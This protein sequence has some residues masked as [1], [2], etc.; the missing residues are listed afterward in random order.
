MS[1]PP[2]SNTSR[3]SS[4]S[5]SFV[6][7]ASKSSSC[8]SRLAVTSSRT[9]FVR[10]LRRDTLLV[11]M[12][13]ANNETGVLQPVMEVAGL[14]AG[15]GVLF[16]VDAAQTFGKE[17]EGLRRVSIV[18]SC[19]SAVTR[20]TGR[21]GSVRSTFAGRGVETDSVEA[22]HVGRR[23]RDGAE[24]RHSAGATDRRARDSSRTGREGVP[25]AKAVKPRG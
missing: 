19:R 5:T 25:A 13:H 4:R 8:R 3:S 17:V 7:S 24:A 23:S 18:I 12:M 20:S 11:S 1:S 10:R 6:R 16:H 14:L 15:S 21:R 22:A 2:A 9:P